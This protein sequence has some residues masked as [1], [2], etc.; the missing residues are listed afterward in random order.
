MVPKGLEN[1][2][3]H[4]SPPEHQGRGK[5][6]GPGVEQ[7][8]GTRGEGRSSELSGPLGGSSKPLA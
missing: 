7:G 8:S 1:G 3:R 5:G 2:T 4:D 6:Q